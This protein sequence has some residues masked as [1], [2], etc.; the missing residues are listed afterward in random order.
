MKKS[1]YDREYLEF[2]QALKN[3]RET[4]HLTQDQLARKLSVPQSF[5]SKYETGERRLDVIE[6]AQICEA[7]GTSIAQLLSTLS[8]R[9]KYRTDRK[10]SSI[11]GTTTWPKK[12]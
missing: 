7:L 10:S 3:L 5:V 6:T 1:S 12:I 9:V 8:T 4:R 2:R 11:K